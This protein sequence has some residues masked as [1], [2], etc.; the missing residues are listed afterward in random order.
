MVD[1]LTTSQIADTLAL[2]DEQRAQFFF[3]EVARTNSL[4]ILVDEHGCVMLNTED[5]DCVPVW[6]NEAFA[7]AWATD[8]WKACKA[9][10]ISTNKW[11]SRWT[12][13]LEE[14]NLALVVFPSEEEQGLVY[15]PQE[16]EFELKQQLKK[17]RK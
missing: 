14:D 3:K 4:W 15:Y 6:P 1:A 17:V 9:Q 7:N 10:A 11:F 13:G 2:N 12:T 5:E 8:E 16:L